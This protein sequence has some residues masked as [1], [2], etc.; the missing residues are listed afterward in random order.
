MRRESVSKQRLLQ[1]SDRPSTREASN[2]IRVELK[3]KTISVM[4]EKVQE[5][6]GCIIIRKYMMKI[7]LNSKM[8]TKTR[9][10]R[11]WILDP[12]SIPTPRGWYRT[13]KRISLIVPWPIILTN[14]SVLIRILINMNMKSNKMNVLSN[15]RSCQIKILAI[16]IMWNHHPSC[17]RNNLNLINRNI[18]TTREFH[19]IMTEVEDQIGSSLNLNRSTQVD[20][21]HNQWLIQLKM[22]TH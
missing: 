16:E 22:L 3:T 2:W 18:P 19:L 9:T 14:T 12:I 20:Q 1:P 21:D 4:K 7:K 8:N 17:N 6:R 10:F 15:Q 11:E 13:H 5:R